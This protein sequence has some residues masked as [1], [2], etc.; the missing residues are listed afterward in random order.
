MSQE[1]MQ[2]IMVLCVTLALMEVVLA[3]SF[4]IASHGLIPV[5]RG[6]IFAVAVPTAQRWRIFSLWW[7]VMV[8]VKLC[9]GRV[10]VRNRSVCSR[11]LAPKT[12]KTTKT[13]TSPLPAEQ[14]AP[15][16]LPH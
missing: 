12:T 4:C 8:I 3:G 16:S 13:T 11:A 5:L 2:N 6:L 7:L 1:N 9:V 10:V 14:G 15:A